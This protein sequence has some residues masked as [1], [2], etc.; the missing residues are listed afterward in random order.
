M[1]CPSQALQHFNSMLTN[2]QL[3][4][5]NILIQYLNKE[6]VIET[7]YKIHEVITVAT[8]SSRPTT[9]NTEV[10]I[11]LAPKQKNDVAV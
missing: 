10:V 11:S 7:E 8:I 1:R 9:V 6:I 3:S 5:P 4:S 2:E